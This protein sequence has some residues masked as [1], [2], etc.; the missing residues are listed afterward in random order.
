MYGNMRDHNHVSTH[1]GHPLTCVGD[2]SLPP[3]PQNHVLCWKVRTNEKFARLVGKFSPPSTGQCI[4]L[5]AE[6]GETVGCVEGCGKG[7]RLKL[8]FCEVHGVCTA[9][10]RG[11][12]G[13]CCQDGSGRV[14]EDYTAKASYYFAVSAGG[15]GDHL[16]ALTVAAGWKARN[17]DHRL[18][19]V[20]H[21]G[22]WARREW[23]QLFEGYDSLDEGMRGTKIYPQL[24]A[25]IRSCEFTGAVA[26]LDSGERAIPR[27]RPLPKEALAWA[28][29]FRGKIV[30]C[31]FAAHPVREWPTERW[32]A[33]EKLLDRK[34]VIVGGGE[35]AGG[36]RQFKSETFAGR[37]PTDIAALFKTAAIV[38]ANESGMAHLAGLLRS[39]CIVVSAG[40]WGANV[41]RFYKNTTVICEHGLLNVE[42]E[43][44]ANTIRGVLLRQIKSDWPGNWH[45]NSFVIQ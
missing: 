19:L 37:P 27:L 45:P 36:L 20:G 11:E 9:G 24:D 2:E 18:V 35:H 23:V 14:C 5:G 26:R 40:V 29:Q 25:G 31:P 38:V 17:P 3:G 34:A 28:E 33:L 21:K 32:V 43:A 15:I 44:V 10:R 8:F 6:T 39:A 4:H 42:P 7:R 1:D 22:N 30:L 41:H 13:G 12:R 16:M